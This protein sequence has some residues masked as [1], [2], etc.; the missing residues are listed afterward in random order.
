KVR[1]A[2]W[3]AQDQLGWDEDVRFYPYWEKDSGVKLISPESNR[4]LASAYSKGGKL[5]LAVL[6]DTDREQTVR[7]DL[8][9]EKLGVH[10]GLKGQDAFQQGKTYVLANTWEDV[11]PPP[12]IPADRLVD[13]MMRYATPLHG[14]GPYLVHKLRIQAREL[15]ENGARQAGPL[16]YRV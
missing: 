11:V 16:R 1:E 7:L 10:P 5:L 8:N 14:T 12:R 3:K 2:V 6:N 4:V 13:S 15:R 9:L